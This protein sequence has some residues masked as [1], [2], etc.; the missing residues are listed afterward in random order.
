M[1]DSFYYDPI[2]GLKYHFSY[3]IKESRAERRKKKV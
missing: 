2:Q 3:E 1:Q